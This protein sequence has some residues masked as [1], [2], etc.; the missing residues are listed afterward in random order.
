[1][2]F[3]I[4]AYPAILCVNLPCRFAHSYPWC[5]SSLVALDWLSSHVFECSVFLEPSG[6]V[7]R[8]S[9]EWH[10][11]YYKCLIKWNYNRTGIAWMVTHQWWNYNVICAFVYIY[12]IFVEN[13][14]TLKSFRL[15]TRVSND[16]CFNNTL[17]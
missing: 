3:R 4:I 10:Q 9:S 12:I 7:P 2:S 5:Q 15:T 17:Q 13:I 14:N 11:V 8:N 16:V 6:R 1:V